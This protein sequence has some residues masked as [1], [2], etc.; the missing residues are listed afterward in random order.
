MIQH[1]MRDCYAIGTYNIRDKYEAPAPLTVDMG[2]TGMISE[3]LNAMDT[4]HKE[5]TLKD[6]EKMPMV[7]YV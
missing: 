1:V 7:C 2:T 3:K 6:K 5:E 4:R